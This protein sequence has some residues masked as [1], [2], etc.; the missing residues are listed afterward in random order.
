MAD[1]EVAQPKG[2]A[3]SV[4]AS[5][6]SV[7]S[8]YAG[9]RPTDVE[10]VIAGTRVACV[11]KDAVHGFDAGIAAS[12]DPESAE[13]PRRLTAWTYRNAAIA[14]VSRTTKR[15]VLAF[16]SKHDAK[17]DTATEVFILD[18]PPR[19]PPPTIADYRSV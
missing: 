15:K 8:A 7:W 11:I 4:S 6:A 17:T 12:V 13:D 9:E 5:L 1:T 14:A 18:L 3:A 19:T 2:M 16:M 10:T